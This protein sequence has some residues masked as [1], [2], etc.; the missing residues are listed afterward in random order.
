M[1]TGLTLFAR[2]NN[3]LFRAIFMDKNETQV[4]PENFYK[5]FFDEMVNDELAGELPENYCREV[6]RRMSIFT[7][8][9]AS[10]ICAGIIKDA[11]KNFVIETM[12]EM[13]RDVIDQAMFKS[14]QGGLPRSC[15]PR[16]IA[17]MCN[18]KSGQRYRHM[19]F[20]FRVPPALLVTPC[21]P[22]TTRPR[23]R[24]KPPAP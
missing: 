7:H 1:G 12:Y 4:I 10:L 2:D 5:I 9:L 8:G 3:E 20:H 11:G 16:I 21:R 17:P 18:G 13:G 24:K 19:I 23:N 15:A 22:P 14:R 6:F